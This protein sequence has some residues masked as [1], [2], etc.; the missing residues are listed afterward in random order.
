MIFPSFFSD[1]IYNVINNALLALCEQKPNDPVDFLSRKMLELIGDNPNGI[2]N[3][4]MPYIIKVATKELQL[5]LESKEF[6]FKLK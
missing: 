1:I 5:S 3:N 6:S 4:L 2:P